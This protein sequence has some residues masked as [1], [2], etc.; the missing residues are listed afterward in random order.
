MSIHHP[1][2]LSAF[3][4]AMAIFVGCAGSTDPDP[5]SSTGETGASVDPPAAQPSSSESGDEVD[6][7]ATEDNGALDSVPEDLY[8]AENHS[9]AQVNEIGGKQNLV[10]EYAA[11]DT[12]S[13]VESFHNGMKEKGWTLLTSSEL[14]IGTIANFSKDDRKCTISIAPPKDQIIKVAIVLPQE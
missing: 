10:L 6:T 4:F 1:W 12:E 2:S 8:I 13:F 3:L 9:S 7:P 14:P 11:G 5:S